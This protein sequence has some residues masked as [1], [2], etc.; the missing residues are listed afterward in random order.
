V[1][2][3]HNQQREADIFIGLKYSDISAVSSVENGYSK[4]DESGFNKFC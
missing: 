3:K 2:K 1:C 4:E